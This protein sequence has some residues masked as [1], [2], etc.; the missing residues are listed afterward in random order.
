LITKIVANLSLA[1]DFQNR[2]RQ[3]TQQE[4]YVR[5]AGRS[6]PLADDTPEIVAYSAEIASARSPGR[7]HEGQ[8]MPSRER[9]E[10]ADQKWPMIFGDQ[11]VT[12]AAI[13]RLIHHAPSSR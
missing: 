12:L 13:D 3:P 1:N 6:W 10:A 2:M 9:L 11:A 5:S 7:S 4:R 8:S